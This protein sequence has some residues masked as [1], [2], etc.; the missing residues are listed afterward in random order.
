MNENIKML[1][2]AVAIYALL[3]GAYWIAEYFN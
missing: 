1:A 2:G 3:V